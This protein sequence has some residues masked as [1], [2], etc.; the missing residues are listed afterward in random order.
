[1]AKG[2]IGLGKFSQHTSIFNILKVEKKNSNMT[3]EKDE[4]EDKEKNYLNI[5]TESKD[6]SKIFR[7]HTKPKYFEISK[8]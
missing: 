1:M 2:A 3:I 4:R 8:K 6:T 7:K 5:G